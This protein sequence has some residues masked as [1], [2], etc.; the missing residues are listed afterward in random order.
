MAE[1]VSVE[2]YLALDAASETKHEYLNGIV[3]AMAGASPR[4]NQVVSNLVRAL[5]NALELRP[6]LV[7]GS[8]QR[9]RAVETNG[10]VYPDLTVVCDGP[11]FVGERPLS[12]EN[13]T[14]IIEVLSPSTRDYDRG[15][16]LAHYRRMPSVR[17]ILLVESNERRA[18]LYRRIERGWLL[19][20]IV[21]GEIE[22]ASVDVRVSFDAIYAKTDALPLEPEPEPKAL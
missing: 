21:G 17:E 12:L 13:P 3:V 1:P 7:L 22:L 20:D 19:T 15:A 9:V 6:S 11:R 16:K 4:H 10:Y 14:L 2:D 8:Q 18:E 5:G